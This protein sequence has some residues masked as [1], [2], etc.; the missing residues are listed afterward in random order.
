M[1][2]NIRLNKDFY[3]KEAIEK[4]IDVFREICTGKVLNDS[5]DVELDSVESIANLK[6]EF[7]NYVL[8]LMR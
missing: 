1:K 5:I 2:I 3:Q 8:G 6:D 7:V 4:A